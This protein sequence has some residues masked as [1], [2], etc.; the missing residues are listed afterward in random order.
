[1]IVRSRSPCGDENCQT[2]RNAETCPITAWMVRIKHG[3]PCACRACVN[4]LWC[5]P[6]LALQRAAK[7]RMLADEGGKS[8]F[9]L[10]SI[11]DFAF[12]FMVL[13]VL[14]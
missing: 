13:T 3:A 12:S 5:A 6:C 14:L 9:P 1:V 8:Y 11:S 7:E 4:R 10:A 2:A